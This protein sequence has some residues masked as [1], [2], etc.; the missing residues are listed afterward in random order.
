MRTPNYN[1]P[2][3]LHMT[4]VYDSKSRGVEDEVATAET[5]YYKLESRTIAEVEANLKS[6]KK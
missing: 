6:P 1:L 2:L 3:P 4:D 5:L